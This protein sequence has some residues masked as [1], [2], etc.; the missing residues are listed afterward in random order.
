MG[1]ETRKTTREKTSCG[2][3]TTGMWSHFLPVGR[4]HENLKFPV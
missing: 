3:Q 4:L 2:E 1:K